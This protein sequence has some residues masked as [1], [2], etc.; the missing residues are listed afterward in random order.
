MNARSHFSWRGAVAAAALVAALGCNDGDEPIAPE[1]QASLGS[2]AESAEHGRH[3]FT[4]YVQN[5]YLGGDTDPIFSIDFSNLPAV[6][7]AT[8]VF[9]AQVRASRIPERAAGIVD[10]IAARRPHMVGLQ[11]ATQFDVLDMGAGGVVV[12]AVDM[13]GSIQAEISQRGLPYELVRAQVNSVVTLPL[14]PTV[15]LRTTDRVAVLRRTDVQVGAVA[16]A[17]Y[18]ATFSLGPVILKRGWIRVAA[19]HE[20]ERYNFIVTHLE[21]QRLAPI[22]AAQA[23]E[24]IQSVSAG[25]EGITMVTGDLNSDPE[26]PGAPSWTPTYDAMIAAGFTDLW[27][28]GHGGD[29]GYTCCQAADLM[30]AGSLL[31][32]RIDFVMVRDPHA[33][34]GV[35]GAAHI[36]VVGEEQ[37]DRTASGLWRADHA[38]LFAGYKPAPGQLARP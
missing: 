4:A 17:N 34:N 18:A 9:W 35:Q 27:E 37:G 36:Q 22:Q 28:R 15:V 24:L 12:E 2:E 30:N 33:E 14:S 5:T 11:E 13:L 1:F 19:E 23:S 21:T 29:V 32:E 26:H 38:G 7:Q 31:D 25:L 16:S 8:N 3:A 20:G 10:E 6:I